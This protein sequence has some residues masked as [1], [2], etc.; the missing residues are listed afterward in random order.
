MTGTH[1]ESWISIKEPNKLV[2]CE[3]GCEGT[4]LVPMEAQNVGF[5]RWEQRRNAAPLEHVYW[6]SPLR[7]RDPFPHHRSGVVWGAPRGRLLPR[8]RGQAARLLELRQI[9]AVDEGY[10]DVRSRGPRRSHDD[11]PRQNDGL[12]SWVRRKVAVLEVFRS[13]QG[14]EEEGE[15]EDRF[16]DSFSDWLATL[17][18]MKGFSSWYKLLSCDMVSWLLPWRMLNDILFIDPNLDV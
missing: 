16:Q 10:H 5:R 15:A 8:R 4:W 7:G 3:G 13:R 18:T 14:E 1:I 2:P 17:D 9:R 6:A 11:E 12:D